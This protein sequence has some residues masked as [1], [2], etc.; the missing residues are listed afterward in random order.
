MQSEVSHE[1]AQPLGINVRVARG[2]CN[3][4][5]TEERLDVEQVGSALVKK[6]GGGRIP[7]G[8]SGNDWYPRALAGELEAYVEGLVAKG[9]AIPARKDQ[10]RS[11]E[12]DSPRPQPYAL[13]AFQESELLLEQAT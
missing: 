8:V 2:C 11:R 6:E 3:T 12:V 4:L 9:R 7:Q 5:M 1:R 10:R 13:D